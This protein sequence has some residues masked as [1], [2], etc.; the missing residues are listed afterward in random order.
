[1]LKKIFWLTVI[2]CL[3]SFG[4]TYKHNTGIDVND[5][6]YAAKER[7]GKLE[8]EIAKLERLVEYFSPKGPIAS[9]LIG[10]KLPSFVARINA[11]L[12]RFGFCCEIELEPYSIR[13]ST[14][15]CPAKSK[16]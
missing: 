4:Q 16:V 6:K 2:A 10:G 12:L 1:M 13:V 9:A 3:P 11:V 15:P 14:I 8:Q 5:P 7:R